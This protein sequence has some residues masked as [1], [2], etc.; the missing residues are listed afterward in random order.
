MPLVSVIIPCHN[1][2]KSLLETINS[3]ENQEYKNIEIII[4]NDGSNE[5]ETN[6]LLDGLI[7]RGLTVYNIENRGVSYARNYGAEKAK[8]KYIIFVDDDDLIEKSY[9]NKAVTVM[10]YNDE[11]SLVYCFAKRFGKDNKVWFIRRFSYNK[12][13]Q[14]NCLFISSLI[15]RKDF[16]LTTGFS[17]NMNMGLEDW[18][19]WIR[20]LHKKKYIYRINDILFFYRINEVSR[21]TSLVESKEKI[22]RM[23]L[24]VLMNNFVIYLE[25]NKALSQFRINKVENHLMKLIKKFNYLIYIFKVVFYKEINRKFSIKRFGGKLIKIDN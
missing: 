14:K 19:F 23:N 18:D 11:I 10:E 7:N 12:L 1:S 5:L 9:I 8:G 25:Y 13:L 16:L 20:F 2:R 3:L 17:E 6:I 21:T 22:Y 4:I 24:N 15:K